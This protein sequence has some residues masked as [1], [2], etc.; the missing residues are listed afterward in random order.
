MTPPTSAIVQLLI[1]NARWI[2]KV[3]PDVGEAAEAIQ[4]D[5]LCTKS[6]ET[7]LEDGSSKGRD[8]PPRYGGAKQRKQRTTSLSGERR[9]GEEIEGG[10][11]ERDGGGGRE[12]DGGGGREGWRGEGERD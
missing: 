2:G 10:E 7:V 8:L 11:G 6:L 5:L 1:E 4:V 9:D 12:R 3:P